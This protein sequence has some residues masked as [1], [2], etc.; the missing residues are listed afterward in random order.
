M[1]LIKPV[2]WVVY[3]SVSNF[4]T[5]T[6][7]KVFRWLERCNFPNQQ[8]ANHRELFGDVIS[9]FFKGSK[10]ILF[11]LT[12]K[13]LR[14][15]ILESQ[16]VYILSIFIATKICYTISSFMSICIVYVLCLLLLRLYYFIFSLLNNLWHPLLSE[17][18]VRAK[19]FEQ[20]HIHFLNNIHS[21]LII[22]PYEQ[23]HIIY[24][25]NGKV[26]LMAKTQVHT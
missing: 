15:N 21:F 12:R 23:S 2:H 11:W 4:L 22:L 25:D 19:P 6:F 26:S 1:V 20:S 8:K 16:W 17:V 10:I 13:L 5:E 24:T 3:W 18:G 9:E 14:I 7:R